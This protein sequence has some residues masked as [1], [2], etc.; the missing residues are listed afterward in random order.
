MHQLRAVADHTELLLL[1][2]REEARSID[3]DEQRD[4]EE[5]AGPHEARRLL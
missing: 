3:E 1:G 5:V 2:A 4:T